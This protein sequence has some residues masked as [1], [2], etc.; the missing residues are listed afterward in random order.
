MLLTFQLVIEFF[1]N[2]KQGLKFLW[3]F[4]CLLNF[5]VLIFQQVNI[6][7]KSTYTVCSHFLCWLLKNQC[8]RSTYCVV[9]FHQHIILSIIHKDESE[10]KS[11]YNN[12]PCW[13]V[14]FEYVKY[15][16]PHANLYMSW[17]NEKQWF[18]HE[19]RLSDLVNFFL[20]VAKKNQYSVRLLIRW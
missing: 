11:N 18:H 13:C 12:S 17:K 8:V 3:K 14:S 1:C 9:S 19:A 2:F 15:L 10:R 5:S 4:Q 6:T 16:R 7:E 20:W